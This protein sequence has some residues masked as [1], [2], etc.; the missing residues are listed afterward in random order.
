MPLTP[1][2]IHNVAFKKP[3]LGKRG[4]DEEEVDAFLD[5]AE[6][7]MI[8]LLEENEALR[9]RMPRSG[10]GPALSPPSSSLDGERAA[11]AA[12]L[13]RAEE[14]R[15]RADQYARSLQAELER[16][17]S[18]AAPVS[19]IGGDRSSRGS[20]VM[21]MAQRTADDHMADARREAEAVMTAA[22]DQSVQITSD[23]RRNA[24]STESDA[25]RRHAEAINN[26][27]VE[28]AALL[29]EIERL[30]QL[31]ESYQTALSNHVTQQLRDMESVP[32]PAAGR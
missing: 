32:E 24:G 5:E 15:A 29:D 4:Y 23:A 19:G 28:R 26:L 20:A 17:P 18:A 31:A 6:Q 12:Q 7:Q 16:A 1:A 22:R 2:D 8:R 21:M 25:R 3:P 13:Q 14:D 9:T 30:A 27:E 11:V 10:G